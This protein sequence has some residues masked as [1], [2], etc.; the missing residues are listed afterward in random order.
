MKE[1][2]DPGAA[3]VLCLEA[4]PDE[5][6]GNGYVGPNGGGACSLLYPVTFDPGDFDP[7]DFDPGDFDN[8]ILQNRAGEVIH[9]NS[10]N[11]HGNK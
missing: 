3:P 8:P 11:G 10:R 9:H 2:P 4:P 1:R 7:G 5:R 6:G